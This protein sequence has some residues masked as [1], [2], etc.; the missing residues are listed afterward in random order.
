MVGEISA[1][2]RTEVLRAIRKPVQR[3]IEEGQEPHARRIRSHSGLPQKA[4]GQASEER[5]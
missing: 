2:T 5:L 3:G 4:R 1:V